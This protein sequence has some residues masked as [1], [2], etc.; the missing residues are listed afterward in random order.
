M[1]INIGAFLFRKSKKIKALE[2]ELKQ[3]RLMEFSNLEKNLILGALD[4]IK[5]K[6]QA[7]QTKYIVR[8]IY[9]DLKRKLK[10]SMKCL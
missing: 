3:I 9:R 4:E 1:N 7:P 10:A 5:A 2:R 8:N 6:I